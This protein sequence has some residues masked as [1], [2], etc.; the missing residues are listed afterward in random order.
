MTSL[1]ILGV[2][3]MLTGPAQA[4]AEPRVDQDDARIERW[5]VETG[6]GGGPW[7]D[8][9]YTERLEDFGFE[10]PWLIFGPEV[11]MI[12]GSVV[13]SPTRNLGLVFTA[14][15]LDSDAWNRDM[16]RYDA[17]VEYDEHY[18]WTTWRG[19]FYARGSLPLAQGWITPYVQAGGGPALTLS[20]YEDDRSEDQRTDLG[21]HLAAA[22][23]MQLMLA[24]PDHRHFGLYAQ[25]ET[26]TAPVLENLAGDVHD[27][28]RQ[29][30]MFGVRLGY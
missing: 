2:A 8:T 26:C 9:A 5:F 7:R 20:S 11:F 22:A 30:F 17:P 13:H 27:S 3:A 1:P 14:G 18:R 15:N 28:G 23:G 4:H 21:W 25:A 29:A 10:R 16:T 24:I 6:F 19:G 12:Q